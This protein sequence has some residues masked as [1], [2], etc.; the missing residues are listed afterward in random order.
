M[1]KSA[2]IAVGVAVSFYGQLAQAGATGRTDQVTWYESL[3]RFRTMDLSADRAWMTC[4]DAA[5][6]RAHGETLRSDMLRAIGPLPERCP[7]EARVTK[8]EKRAEYSI[9][10][11]V[12]ASRPGFYLTGLFYRPLGEGPFPAVAITCGHSENGKACNKYQRWALS[13][14]KA[15]IAAFVYDPIDQGERIFSP[16]PNC[17]GHNQIGARATLLGSSFSGMRIYD[18]MRVFDYLES[19]PDV[20]RSR[21]GLSGQSGGGTM[22]ALT[23]VLEPRIKA[24]TPSCYVSTLRDVCSTIGP[25]DAEQCIWNQLAFGLNHLGYVC[26]RTPMPVMILTTT[27]DF[28]PLAGA[29]STASLA[30]RVF[31]VAGAPEAFRRFESVGPHGVSESATR[32]SVA[33]M[34]KYLKGEQDA[35][36]DSLLD[37]L[38]KGDAGFDLKKADCGI[39]EKEV[40]VCPGASVT[41]LPGAKTVY[42]LFREKTASFAAARAS[43]PPRGAARAALV[44]RIAGIRTFDEMADAKVTTNRTEVTIARPDA[45]TLEGY[46]T[47]ASQRAAGRRPVLL[48]F[49]AGWWGGAKEQA[50]QLA[51]KGVPS[52]NAEIR[53]MGRFY[54]CKFPWYSSTAVLDGVAMLEH[55]MGR[56]FVS[57]CAEDVAFFARELSRRYGGGPVDVIAKGPAAVSVAHAAAAYPELFAEVTTIAPPAS[58]CARMADAS[59]DIPF[60]QVVRGALRHYDWTDLVK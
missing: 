21:L 54:G 33:W 39:P 52:L 22:T 12:F 58:W 43:L 19:R 36:N 17:S 4:E 32:A 56:N 14:A 16:N 24:A 44:R 2:M 60:A 5:A 13:Y 37:E 30:S 8:T 11:V 48:V 46:F 41:N 49:F 34:R 18:A 57:L 50:R 29:K 7:L 47:D 20:D 25:Q 31:A 23:M 10:S 15:G 3:A 27:K 35:W 55:M 53:N 42:D 1:V 28:F 45:P 40:A 38:P 26:A 59:A 9:E 51:E 6:V